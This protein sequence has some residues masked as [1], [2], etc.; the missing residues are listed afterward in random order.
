MK[1]FGVADTTFARFN[2]GG[3][4]INQLQS[5]GT[6]LSIKRYT[7]PGIKDL[8]V[9][10]LILFD[11]GCDI[12]IAC[13]M[14]GPKPVDKISSQVASTGLMEVQ[15]K[16]GKHVVEVFV[17]EDE[18]KDERELSWLCDRRSREHAENAF[19]LIFNPELLTRKAGTGQRQGFEDV[20]QVGLTSRG[21]NLGH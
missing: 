19:N 21:G 6:N 17:H 14:P 13:G 11:R 15:L 5:M 20:G 2:M 3:S 9:A 1:L 16:T 12:V 7:V 18:A 4:V 10:S 8:A